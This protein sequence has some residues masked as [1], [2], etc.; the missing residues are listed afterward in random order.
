M[1][2]ERLNHPH[3]LSKHACCPAV[4]STAH[5]DCWPLLPPAASEP[6]LPQS[7]S[8]APPPP[9]SPL[10][11]PQ[12]LH[13]HNDKIYS[14][15]CMLCPISLTWNRWICSHKEKWCTLATASSTKKKT[16][17]NISRASRN[18]ASMFAKKNLCRSPARALRK[19]ALS[20]GI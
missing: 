7:P 8:R 18:R 11:T 5:N 19:G 15:S 20:F 4:T 12:P 2:K 14:T 13:F 9:Q 3:S 6:P 1:Q 16:T 17:Q 10:Q